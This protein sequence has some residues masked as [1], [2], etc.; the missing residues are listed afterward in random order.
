M[1]AELQKDSGLRILKRRKK[2]DDL[3][4]RQYEGRQRQGSVQYNQPFSSIE[5]SNLEA[6]RNNVQPH[7]GSI[8]YENTKISWIPLVQRLEEDKLMRRR[9]IRNLKIN[10]MPIFHSKRRNISLHYFTNIEDGKDKLQ[11]NL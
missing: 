10:E 8:E 11:S 9:K 1:D 4:V 6:S 7:F 3:K 2:Q 5:F